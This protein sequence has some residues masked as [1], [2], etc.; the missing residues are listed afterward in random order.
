MAVRRSYGSVR[1]PLQRPPCLLL[2]PACMQVSELFPRAR[3]VLVTAGPEGAAYCFRSKGGETS[4]F[5][6]AFKVT[7]HAAAQACAGPTA[8]A[9]AHRPSPIMFKQL[10]VESVPCCNVW[11][12]LVACICMYA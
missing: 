3:G 5:V 7:G 12:L 11:R 1:V 9:H 6:P 4:A 10:A 8:H 2:R